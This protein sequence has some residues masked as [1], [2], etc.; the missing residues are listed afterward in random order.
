MEKK[1]FEGA[2]GMK[3]HRHPEAE[4]NLLA[5]AENVDAIIYSKGKDFRYVIL[6]S[7]LRKKLIDLFE[8]GDMG[9]GLIYASQGSIDNNIP[10]L[11][12]GLKRK[13]NELLEWMMEESSL[14]PDNSSELLKLWILESLILIS[15]QCE[16]DA[17]KKPGRKSNSLI[18]KFKKLVDENFIKLGLPKDYAALLFVTPN[19]LNQISHKVLGKTAGEV[20][21]DRKMLEAKRLLLNLDLNI[22]QIANNLNFTDPSHFSKFFKKY[23]G[24]SP[25]DFR[26]NAFGDVQ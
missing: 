12:E 4:A 13:V 11:P 16:G 8:S 10:H 7:A 18:S 19:Y 22:S 1:D 26:K 20:I 5:V 9:R 24:K 3:I 23:T 21:R 14:Y 2:D 6:S 15:N 17:A 25:E